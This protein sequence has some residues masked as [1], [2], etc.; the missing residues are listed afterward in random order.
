MTA[1]TATVGTRRRSLAVVSAMIVIALVVVALVLFK[2][3]PAHGMHQVVS[4]FHHL[5]HFVQA[6]FGAQHFGS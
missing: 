1:I 2:I 4:A 3:S 5:P 6:L